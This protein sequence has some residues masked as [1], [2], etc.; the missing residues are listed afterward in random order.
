[1]GGCASG[2]EEGIDDATDFTAGT[3]ECHLP[4]GMVQVFALFAVEYLTGCS[5]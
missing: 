3:H 5:L 1:M 2:N 4:K